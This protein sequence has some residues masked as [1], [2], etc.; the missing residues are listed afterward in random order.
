[1]MS[2][3]VI[4]IASVS[5][6]SHEQDDRYR[7]EINICDRIIKRYP[8]H[9][10]AWN[11][12][13]YLLAS[14]GQYEAAAESYR[15]TLSL[16]ATE[17]RVWCNYGAVLEKLE[18]LDEAS[19]CFSKALKQ[20]PGYFKA[21]YRQSKNLHRR[22]LYGE[23]VVSYEQ[24]IQLRPDF[25][26]VWYYRG[27]ALLQ[28]NRNEQAIASLTKAT[29]LYDGDSK[30]WMILGRTL[31][32]EQQPQEALN[33]LNHALRIDPND[34]TVWSYHAAALKNLGHGEDAF[35]SLEKAVTLDPGDSRLWHLRGL[36]L[37]EVDQL[38]TARESFI[39]SLKIQAY[40][41]QGWLAM[42]W[43]L[44]KM[45][46]YSLAIEAYDKS[47]A[48]EPDQPFAFYNQARCHARLGHDLWALEHLRRAMSLDPNIYTE[49]AYADP[50]LQSILKDMEDDDSG[51]DLEEVERIALD[52]A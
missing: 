35:A 18:A 47:L 50:L 13:S 45:E 14:I 34:A 19:K 42:G 31:L 17:H 26:K 49:R 25:Y 36:A 40:N 22:A 41:Y 8:Y 10:Q 21:Q 28:L 38:A 37:L 44:Q 15:H 27:K 3:Q 46:N 48:I 24:A 1:M 20:A 2:G 5:H 43:T 30:V 4:D 29:E 12:R 39:T 23:A 33:A 51:E 7:L 16:K 6:L 9:Y 52:S 32:Q 11:Y